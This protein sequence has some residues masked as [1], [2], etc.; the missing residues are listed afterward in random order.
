M[1]AYANSVLPETIFAIVDGVPKAS[2]TLDASY[3]KLEK[4]NSTLKT[5]YTIQ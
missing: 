5:P 4:F 1:S 2:V 3:G